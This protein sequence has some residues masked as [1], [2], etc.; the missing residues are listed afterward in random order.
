MENIS[1]LD[2]DSKKKIQKYLTQIQKKLSIKND[3]IIKSTSSS[4][5]L[6]TEDES[7]PF[8]TDGDDDE[9]FESPS[10]FESSS[11][12]CSKSIKKR[13]MIRKSKI[14]KQSHSAKRNERGNERKRKMIWRK[15]RIKT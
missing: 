12:R 9:T 4:I 7:D 5:E 3:D 15:I 6:S 10:T 11:P 13:K 8:A 1:D 14:E 2:L